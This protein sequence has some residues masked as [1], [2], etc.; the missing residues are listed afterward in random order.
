MLYQR[1]HDYRKMKLGGSSTRPNQPSLF[2]RNLTQ[3]SPPVIGCLDVQIC[4]YQWLS[5][6]RSEFLTWAEL[7]VELEC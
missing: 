5:S 2:D 3:L 6:R 7:E 1:H 4:T